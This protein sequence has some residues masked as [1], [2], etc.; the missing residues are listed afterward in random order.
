MSVEDRRH[1]YR[2][3]DPHTSRLAAE[4]I[5]LGELEAAVYTVICAAGP[6]G[7]ISDEVRKSFDTLPYSSVTARYKALKEKGLIEI[8]GC[9]PG[10]SGRLQSV[11]RAASHSTPLRRGEP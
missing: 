7:I 9:R 4:S 11:M 5:N 8:I 6:R 1:L 2:A 10:S 3:E